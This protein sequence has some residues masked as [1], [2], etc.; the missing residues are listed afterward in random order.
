MI[1]NEKPVCTCIA[2]PIG[3]GLKIV[4]LFDPY[5]QLEPHKKRGTFQGEEPTYGVVG[6][7]ESTEET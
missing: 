5:C 2:A 1:S 4:R 7:K 6:K 3:A